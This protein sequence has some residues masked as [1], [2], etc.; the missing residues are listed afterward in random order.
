[1]PPAIR[2]AGKLLAQ[3]WKGWNAHN[4]PRMGAALAYYTTFS[5]APM[6]IIAIAVAGVVFGPEAARSEV[7]LQMSGLL[8]A[9]GAKA[10]EEM[11]ANANHGGAGVIATIIGMVTLLLGAS[12]LFAELRSALNLIWDAPPPAKVGFVTMLRTRF[13]S[14]AMVLVIG[15]LLLV[16]L[17]ISATLSGVQSHVGGFISPPVIAQAVNVVVSL[18]VTTSLF[19]L[20]YKVLPD[21]KIAWKDVWVGAFATAILF[22]IGKL[23]IGL[24]LGNGALASS[25]GAAG[26][27]AVML[28]WIYYSAQLILFGAEFTQ[29]YAHRHGSKAGE[30]RAS[31]RP[32]A[33]PAAPSV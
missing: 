13:L 18:I 27:L 12:S 16:S 31:E 4:A 33:A 1:M 20:I 6:L 21:V 15:F 30:D 29:V 28:V 24:Y 17:V 19:A 8:G 9:T 22:A 10:V 25:Y 14:F 2:L 5:M 11:I 7:S 23:I 26:S 3:T 32:V